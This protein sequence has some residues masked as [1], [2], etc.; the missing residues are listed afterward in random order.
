MPNRRSVTYDSESLWPQTRN[1][2]KY[3]MLYRNRTP[4]TR[5]STQCFRCRLSL[6]VLSVLCLAYCPEAYRHKKLGSKIIRMITGFG[7]Q[8]VLIELA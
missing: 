1:R 5:S 8:R 6:S 7:S 3:S 2:T 4:A